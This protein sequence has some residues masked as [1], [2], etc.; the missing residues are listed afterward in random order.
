[1]VFQPSKN[2][3][4]FRFA[5]NIVSEGVTS[6]GR[7]TIGRQPHVLR[8]LVVRPK[9]EH[10]PAQIEKNHPRRA[11]LRFPTEDALLEN[12]GARLILLT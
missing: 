11:R 1:M 2:L 8:Q 7:D 3:V 9:G 5:S 10:D 12:H 6:I 4:D